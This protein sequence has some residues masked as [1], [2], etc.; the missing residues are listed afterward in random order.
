NHEA[1]KPHLDGGRMPNLKRLMTHGT[2]G[3]LWSTT[4]AHT[5]AA[6]TTLST[7]KHPGIHGVM[8]FRRFDP[9]TQQNRLNTTQDVPHKTVWQLLDTVG[10]KVGVVGQPQSY[11]PRPLTQGFAVTGF[12]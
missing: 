10:M 11:P 5:A 1:L 3:I 4:P 6:W 7:G 8:N 9:R 2:S 12:E